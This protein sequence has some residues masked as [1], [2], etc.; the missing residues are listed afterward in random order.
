MRVCGPTWPRYALGSL[1]VANRECRPGRVVYFIFI[2][3]FEIEQARNFAR[4]QLVTD[5][6]VVDVQQLLS[7][8][9]RR[10]ISLGSCG[11]LLYQRRKFPRT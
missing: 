8:P 11:R 6:E 2:I 7:L 5:M 4:L 1:A 3:C 9:A 10:P